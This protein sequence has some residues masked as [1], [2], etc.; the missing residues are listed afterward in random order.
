MPM[1]LSLTKVTP[2]QAAAMLSNNDGNRRLDPK[3]VRKYAAEIKKGQWKTTGD[4]IKLASNGRVL[5]GQHRLAA[6]VEAGTA[7]TVAIAE[8]VDEK[9]FDVL[10]SGKA[11][12]SGDVLKIAGVKSSTATATLARTLILLDAGID[13]ADSHNGSVV[14]K[15]DILEFALANEAALLAAVQIGNNVYNR[16]GGN[17]TGWSS[18]AYRT[19][20]VDPEGLAEF[21]DGVVSGAGLAH[22]DPRL[23]LRNHLAQR[24]PA[25][26]ATSVVAYQRAYNAWAQ[27]RQMS[28]IKP[29]E[30]GELP[31]QPVVRVKRGRRGEA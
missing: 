5:D 15:T 6:I 27:N 9:V 26:R 20:A 30:A 25:N 31:P 1:Q 28:R 29:V 12:T 8:G 11:R 3:R 10:D 24:K 13:P 17:W 18:F 2:K 19:A 22:G 14:S 21:I 7:V 23:G 4:T 16:V